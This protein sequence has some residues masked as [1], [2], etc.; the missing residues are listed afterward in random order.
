MSGKMFQE[1]DINKNK[2]N[3]KK[4]SKQSK[5]GKGSENNQLFEELSSIQRNY[6]VGGENSVESVIAGMGQS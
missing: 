3:S 4:S 5:N 2:E 1:D 6:M